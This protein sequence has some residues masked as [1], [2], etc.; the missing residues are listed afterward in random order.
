[1][2]L[3]NIYSALWVKFSADDILKVFFLCFLLIFPRK[4]DLTFHANCLQL[5]QFARKINPVFEEKLE[6]TGFDIVS[7][8]CQILFSRKN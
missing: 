6:K 1:M 2:K 8:K 7:M 3:E 5:R 4:Q